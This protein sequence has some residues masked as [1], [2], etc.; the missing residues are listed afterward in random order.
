[1][2]RSRRRS[3]LRRPAH[4]YSAAGVYTITVTVTDDDGGSD[5]DSLM[6]VVYDPSAGFVTGGGWTNSP[7]GAYVPDPL[8]TGKATFGFVS[9]YQKGAKIPDGN[10]EFQ[11]HAAGLNFKSD[12]YEWLVVSGPKAQFKGKG[13]LNGTSGYGFL[14]TATDGQ[15]NGGGGTDKFRIKIWDSSNTIVYDNMLG[16][17]DDLDNAQALASGSI[18]IHAKK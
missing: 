14:L 12:S 4:S 11:F 16:A 15:V 13:S 2:P 10:T 5:S 7:A 1:M 18:V 6:V 8:L 3:G 9:K 17:A